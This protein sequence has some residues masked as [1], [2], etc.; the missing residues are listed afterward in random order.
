[1]FHDLSVGLLHQRIHSS[2]V[3]IHMDVFVPFNAHHQFV[4]LDFRHTFLFQI[5]KEEHTKRK[6][7][8]CHSD[9]QF[10]VGEYPVD[11]PIVSTFQPIVLQPIIETFRQ[12]SLTT[13]AHPVEQ[14]IKHRQQHDTRDVRNQQACR[15]GESLIHKDSTGNT[16]HEYQRYEYRNGSKRRTEHRSNHFRGTGCTSPSERI[17]SF[18]VLRNVFR[19]DNRVVNH[20]PHRQNQARKRDD[21]ERHLEEIEQEER[22]N[23][24]HC[25]TQSN[26]NR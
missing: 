5:E 25:H 8:Q 12:E 11:T 2:A 21:I 17:T 3:F 1:M 20:H 10:L 24:R 23:D 7:S 9:T 16:A 22:Y 13:D 6:S 14:E 19:H 15:N 4:L 18:P 26:H